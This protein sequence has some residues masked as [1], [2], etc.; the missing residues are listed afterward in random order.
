VKFKF[1][2]NLPFEC[3]VSLQNAGFDSETVT[4]ENLA[5]ANDAVV[6]EH[7]Q[8]EKRILVTLDLDF[9][10]VQLYPPN[11][12]AG[13]IVLRPPMQDK[14]KLISLVVRLVPILRARSPDQQLWIAE[15]DRIRVR[16]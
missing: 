11:A 6:F 9:A 14:E 3:S 13:V 8:R 5:G 16:E 10:N 2:E 12:H 4:A 15:A 1:D 7:C